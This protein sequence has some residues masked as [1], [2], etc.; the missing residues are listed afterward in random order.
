MNGNQMIV[1]YIQMYYNDPA[2][3]ES[4]V[5]TSQVM[6]AEALKTGIEAHRIHRPRCMGSLYQQ[7]NDT[8][9]TISWSTVDFYGRWKPAHYTVRRSFAN[10]LVVPRLSNNYLKIFVVNDSV[11]P[12]NA[13]LRLSLA[14]FSGKQFWSE[15]DSVSLQ[16][17]SVQLLWKA[18]QDKVCPRLMNS[19][20]YMLVQLVVKQKV[21]AENMLYLAD[22]KFL[23]LPMPDISYQVKGNGDAFELI[24][25]SD[26]LA[27][28]VV[29]DTFEK[30]SHFSDNNV[31]LL[32][33]RELKL[34]VTYAGTREELLTDLKIYSLANSY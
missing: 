3:F 19:K 34:T 4:I 23:D 20:V 1:N 14:D 30:D 12:M 16:A 29:L 10:V 27:K 32:P 15:V 11:Q 13:E 25:V 18:L 7:L 24:L 21:I 6:Q 9:P 31:D 2:D 33:G 26:K 5:Y 22:P 8:W 17:D 28:N